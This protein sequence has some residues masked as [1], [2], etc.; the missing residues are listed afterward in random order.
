MSNIYDDVALLQEQVAALESTATL[1]NSR[2]T[3]VEALDGQML[4]SG[5]DLNDL[6]CGRYIIPTVA[7]AQSLLNAP[8]SATSYTGMLEVYCG[9]NAG[10]KIQKYTICRKDEKFYFERSYYSNAWGA[11]KVFDGTDTGWLN[12]PLT[13]GIAVYADSQVPQ[14][15]K[16]GSTV[17]IRGAV[18]NVLALGVLATLPAGYRPTATI[19]FIQSTSLRTGGFPMYARYTINA[20]G[21]IRL[22]SISDGAS[23][24]ESK[25][26]PLMTAFT[27]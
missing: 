19:T 2:L 12:L 23:F 5:T 18:K 16:I 20:A 3:K 17:F 22:E 7:I 25:W 11:W 9:G 10:Q 27:I 8:T 1:L 24:G 13:T 15:R 26:F 6:E 14:Y 21:E 4:I